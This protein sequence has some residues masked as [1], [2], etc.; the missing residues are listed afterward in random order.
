MIKLGNEIDLESK[1]SFSIY[2]F[3]FYELAFLGI[4]DSNIL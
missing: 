2:L 1:S 3:S 4:K